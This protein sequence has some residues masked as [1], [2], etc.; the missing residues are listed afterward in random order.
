M[1][2]NSPTYLAKP[3]LIKKAFNKIFNFVKKMF[4]VATIEA[5]NISDLFEAIDKGKFANRPTIASSLG[6]YG[7]AAARGNIPGLTV[8]DKKEVLEG[9]NAHFFGK[10][11]REQDGL[12]ALFSKESNT[13]LINEAYEG[14]KTSLYKA[15]ANAVK[16]L[17]GLLLKTQLMNYKK[18][19]YS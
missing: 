17:R 12:A 9:V 1:L 19:R 18:N 4:G 2:G 5:Q 6:E 13:A 3:S 10:I 14:A 8:Y 7:V 11:F 15:G 16:L